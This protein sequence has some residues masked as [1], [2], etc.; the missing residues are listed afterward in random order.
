MVRPSLLLNILS[1]ISSSRG[2]SHDEEQYP[3]PEKF[4]PSRWLP[5]KNNPSDSV[6]PRDPRDFVFGYGRR[7]CPGIHIAQASIW[8]AI[9]SV[10][11]TFNIK[12]RKNSM[13]DD[14]TPSIEFESGIV[15]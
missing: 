15:R 3:Q 1:L 7:V 6:R 13:G 10:L 2:V 9:A 11:A 5:N 14:I 8:I 4:I 12:K